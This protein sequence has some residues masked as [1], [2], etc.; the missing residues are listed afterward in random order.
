[1]SGCGCGFPNCRHAGVVPLDRD[2]WPRVGEEVLYHR[3]DDSR[4]TP[5]TVVK[6]AEHDGDLDL[7]LGD[8]IPALD[9]KHRP[10]PHGW[11]HYD[12]AA[13]RTTRPADDRPEDEA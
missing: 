4:W 2:R 10:L 8:G 9:V 5:A 3:G 13:G 12:E 1:M 7:D 11:L 6:V